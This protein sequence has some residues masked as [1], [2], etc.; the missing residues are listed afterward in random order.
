MSFWDEK[1]RNPGFHASWDDKCL[2][3][4]EIANVARYVDPGA[5]IL[6][7]GC[8]RGHVAKALLDYGPSKI[9]GIDSSA[10]MISG[11]KHDV[12]DV[13]FKV[14][15][16]RRI[17]ER[18]NS[19]DMA[20][21]IRTLINV[22]NVDKLKAI[23]EIHRVLKPNG[24]YVLSEAF[25]GPFRNL[26]SIRKAAGLPELEVPPMNEYIEEEQLMYWLEGKFSFVEIKRFS[27]V[28]YL[29]TRFVRE[30]TDIEGYDTDFHRFAAE[31]ASSNDS[32]FGIQ[33]CYVLGKV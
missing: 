8:A 20:Y 29:M 33:K 23:Q 4:M 15:D 21:T 12:P 10:N 5:V 6:D 25:M 3:D 13:T 7:C 2:I 26:N 28:Y 9:V 14:G 31:L 18:D 11:A 16:I 17:P 30:F 19:Y 27:S 24:I 32:D 1:A 22:P